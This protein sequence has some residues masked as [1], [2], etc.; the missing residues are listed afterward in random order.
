MKYADEFY[1][2]HTDESA[3]SASRVVP[4]VLE[5]M[6]LRSVVDLGCGRGAWLAEFARRGV[7]R[8]R[9]YDGDYVRRDSLRIPR[10]A[11]QAHDLSLPIKDA[12][13]YDLAMSLEVAEH[14]PEA[15]A[16][17]FVQSLC[18]LGDTVLFSAAIPDQ[19]GTGHINEQWPTYWAEKFSRLGYGCRDVIRSRVWAD[20]QV[21]WW[22]AQ[23]TLLFANER[24]PLAALPAAAPLSL[25]HPAL[26]SRK[27]T[28]RMRL[29][30]AKARV[31]AKVGI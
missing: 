15:H 2:F 29:G 9:G 7:E 30:A 25:V 17:S 21:S 19:G 31:L 8:I 27:P 18:G 23:N 10:D 20:A 14:I 3:A 16:D 24:S 28:L 1:N 4:I 26:Y 6:P 11:F 5:L 22:Y 13:R 12:N